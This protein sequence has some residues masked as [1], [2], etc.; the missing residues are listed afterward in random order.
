MNL[1][2]PAL[3][4]GDFEGNDLKFEVGGFADGVDPSFVQDDERIRELFKDWDAE[5]NDP[6]RVACVPPPPDPEDDV[7]QSPSAPPKAQAKPATAAWGTVDAQ[8]GRRL[9]APGAAGSR[10]RRRSAARASGSAARFGGRLGAGSRRRGSA[11]APARRGRCA[12]RPVPTGLADGKNGE[13]YNPCPNPDR[14]YCDDIE[15]ML[16]APR[17][18]SCCRRR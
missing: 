9:A 3:G 8:L 6:N 2:F 15:R 16:Q 1:A 18:R 11:T 4:R 7:I 12:D 17:A 5:T 14:Y 13:Y 10:Q